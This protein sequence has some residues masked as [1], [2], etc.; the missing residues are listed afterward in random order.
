MLLLYQNG[1][2]VFS[3]VIKGCT[4]VLIFPLDS[5]SEKEKAPQKSPWNLHV[6]TDRLGSWDNEIPVDIAD[7]S[8][9]FSPKGKKGNETCFLYS[10]GA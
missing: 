2:T 1:Q 5:L 3:C 10:F 8:V 4:R 7:R 9:P 6:I